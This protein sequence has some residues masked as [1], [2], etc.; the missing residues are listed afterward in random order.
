VLLIHHS[1][2]TLTSNGFTLY[3]IVS[4]FTFA[5]CLWHISCV[6]SKLTLCWNRPELIIVGPVPHTVEDFWRMVHMTKAEIIV[7]TTMIV[8]EGKVMMSTLFKCDWAWS[9][10][11]IIKLQ[12]PVNNKTEG[13]LPL[14]RKLPEILVMR[15]WYILQKTWMYPR[16]EAME[17]LLI[18]SVQ[19]AGRKWDRH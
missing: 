18:V 9:S 12:S 16:G 13:R 8:E 14:K 11:Y 17:D 3:N 5:L 2:P 10:C 15:V 19:Q 6:Y 7:M 4:A 1:T